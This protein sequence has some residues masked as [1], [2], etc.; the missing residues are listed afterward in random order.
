MGADRAI[1]VE[2][3]PAA[4][5]KLQSF[6]VSKMLAKLATEEKADLLI[7]GKQVCIILWYLVCRVADEGH[8]QDS[9]HLSKVFFNIRVT[10]IAILMVEIL[11]VSYVSV[12]LQ[13]S[14]WICQIL[15]LTRNTFNLISSKINGFVKFWNLPPTMVIIPVPLTGRTFTAQ[16][17]DTTD[18]MK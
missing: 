9:W 1:H 5:E 13:Y 17:A 4:Y 2:L 8:K 10:F 15:A 3:N 7:F 12:V 11:Y 6:H 14:A 16:Q 18:G